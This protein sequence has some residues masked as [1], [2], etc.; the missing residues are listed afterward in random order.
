[1]G[2]HFFPQNT[3]S[4]LEIPLVSRQHQGPYNGFN[5]TLS[6]AKFSLFLPRC[7]LLPS[8]LCWCWTRRSQKRSSSRPGWWALFLWLHPPSHRLLSPV[9]DTVNGHGLVCMHLHIHAW[10]T[11]SSPPRGMPVRKSSQISTESRRGKK[12]HLDLSMRKQISWM[13]TKLEDGKN[14]DER[15]G[16]W[17]NL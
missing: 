1:M 14:R 17:C 11:P 8:P 4:S 3:H 5:S 9:G 10:N 2:T 6:T 15:T 13:E 16:W 12:T 7:R